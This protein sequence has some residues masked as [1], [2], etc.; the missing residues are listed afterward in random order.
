[1][2]P[3]SGFRGDGDICG[4]ESRAGKRCGKCGWNRE[5]AKFEPFGISPVGDDDAAHGPRRGGADVS[6]V[7][8]A[9][10]GALSELLCFSGTERGFS[11][12]S[13]PSVSSEL[14]GSAELGRERNSVFL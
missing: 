13:D 9:S 14:R 6:V 4:R 8:R 5:L 1:M 11:Y 2:S 7:M 3:A 12:R 10:I